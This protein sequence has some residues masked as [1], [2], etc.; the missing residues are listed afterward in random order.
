MKKKD[1]IEWVSE[2]ADEFSRVE[3][4]SASID[5]FIEWLKKKEAER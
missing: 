2:M 3:Y 1:C 5:A 4:G